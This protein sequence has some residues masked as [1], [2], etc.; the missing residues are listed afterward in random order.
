MAIIKTKKADLNTHYKKYFQ[1]SMILVLSL[2]IVAFKFSPRTSQK[3]LLKDEGG[4]IINI[5]D[6]P[7]TDHYKKP[8][9]PPR[10]Q[11]PEI[12]TVDDIVDIEFA[13]TD[14]V[15]DA[16]IAP[17]AELQKPSNRIVEEETHIPFFKVEVKPEIIGG[18]ESILKNVYYTEIA[19]RAL[20]EGRVT[21]EFIVNKEG[22]VED[23]TILKGIS[24]QLDLIALNAVKQTKFTPGLQRGKPVVVKM[25]IP[26]VFKL[27]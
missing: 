11:I 13:P 27:K 10:P 24:E 25:T 23:A 14:I 7:Q 3:Q 12:A 17:P 20:I 5:V 4:C 6:I 18:Y 16:I 8:P 21:I 2:L 26:I 19:R 22:S 9:I 15:E 1:I